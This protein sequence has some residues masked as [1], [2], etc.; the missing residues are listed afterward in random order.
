VRKISRWYLKM[1]DPGQL[2][3]APP[4]DPELEVRRSEVP[5]PE[6]SR[7]LYTAVGG[8]WY[9]IDRL[10]WDHARWRAHV[11]RPEVETWVGWL[12]GTPAGYAELLRTVAAVE[13]VYFGLLRDFIGR[14]IGPRLL[15]AA[16][17][18][19]WAHGPS[20]VRLSTCELDGPA[21][22]RTYER[23]G[24]RVYDRREERVLLPDASPGPWPGAGRQEPETRGPCAG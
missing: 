6:F 10:G 13:V 11:D 15:H 12:R 24:F 16:V 8:D 1:T 21:A 20:E 7:F 14:G 3:P 22:L 4:A 18:R 23:A 17:A 9:W 2:A 5:S 19:A